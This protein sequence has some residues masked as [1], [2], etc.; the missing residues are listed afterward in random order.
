VASAGNSRSVVDVQV[1]EYLQLHCR[2]GE[3]DRIS[4]H[5]STRFPSAHRHMPFLDRVCNLGSLLATHVAQHGWFDTDHQCRCHDTAEDRRR[6]IGRPSWCVSAAKREASRSTIAARPFGAVRCSALLGGCQ[7]SPWTAL[8]PLVFPWAMLCSARRCTIPVAAGALA[9]QEGP[10][11][12]L[13]PLEETRLPPAC[14]RLLNLLTL[15]CCD[16]LVCLP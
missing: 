8:D 9:N 15:R 1:I 7:A 13:Q 5:D 10:Q 3:V 16:F 4:Q 14:F 11:H 6:G 12:P 2:L